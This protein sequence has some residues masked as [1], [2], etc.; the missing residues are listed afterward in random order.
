VINDD[1]ATAVM[2]SAARKALGPAAVLTAPQSM[3]GEDFSWYLEEI[4]GS[5]ARL[6]VR[7]PSTDLDLHAALFDADERAIPVGVRVMAQTAI[8][9]LDHYGAV[10]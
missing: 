2:A 9:A 4:P 7:I 1:V 8:E 6:G 10:G 5:M 3:G